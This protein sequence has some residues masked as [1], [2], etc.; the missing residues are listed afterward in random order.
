M[1]LF[2]PQTHTHT[3]MP[4]AHTHTHIQCR[5]ARLDAADKAINGLNMLK[6]MGN[7]II[8]KANICRI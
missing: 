6:L 3:A 7:I 8:N 4:A 2:L 5:E 1:H